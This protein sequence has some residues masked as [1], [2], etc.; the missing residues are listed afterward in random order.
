MTYEDYWN[1]DS[2]LVRAYRKAAQIQRDLANQQAWLNGMYV[3]NAI[4][5]VLPSLNAF[6]PKR[7]SKYPE[8]PFEFE[9][10]QKHEP[11]QKVET[12]QHKQ[13][14]KAK[15]MMEIFALNFNKRFEK[16]GGGDGK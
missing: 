1:R 4:C 6:K 3:Y 5:C 11:K 10:A 8:Q 7:P 9:S 12:K 13:D 16:G 15:T 2:T 14:M